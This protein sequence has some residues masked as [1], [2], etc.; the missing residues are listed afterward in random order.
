MFARSIVN[1]GPPE[2]NHLVSGGAARAVVRLALPLFVSAI[3][4]NVQ[5]L[6]DLFWIGRIGSDAVAALALSGTILMMMFPVVLGMSVGTV[7]LVS[8]FVGAE[9]YSDASNAAGQSLIV[10]FLSGIVMGLAGWRYAGD[11]CRL[12][13]AAPA[14]A[15]YATEYLRVCFLGSFT[16]FLLFIGNSSLQGAGNTIL[17]MRVMIL[18]NVVN[19]ALDPILIFGLLGLPRLEVQGAALA[20]VL[21]QAGAAAITLSVLSAG[22]AGIRTGI[23]RWALKPAL[24]W[25]ILRTGLP[26]S[27]QMLSRS[28]MGLVLMRI[29]AAHGTPA[30]AAYGIALRFQMLILMPAFAL[31]NAAAAM[32]GQNL[33]AGLPHRARAA[34]WLAT[35]MDMGIMV[36]VSI[37]LMTFAPWLIRLFDETAQVVAIGT[38]YLRTV[39]PFYVFVALS[40]VLGR[41]LQGAGDT[42]SPMICTIVSLWG[43]QVPLAVAL[44]RRVD[45]PTLGIWWAIALA[46]TVNGLLLAGW[47]QTGRWKRKQV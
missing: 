1:T 35:A 32:V 13:G 10:A 6:I 27:G 11:L 46:V 25:R 23:R 39:P 26:S 18:A 14:V 2:R 45:P 21:S 29:V 19:A 24:A 8:R 17:P 34:A 5:S 9:R 15:H 43:L 44:S 41:S 42:V 16:V 36:S 28:L 47:F 30:V 22:V 33:G 12:L 7:A 3:L 4:Q 40:I 31:G 20:T 37:L 38:S